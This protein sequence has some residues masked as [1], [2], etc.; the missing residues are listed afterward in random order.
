[1]K[2]TCEFCKW[3]NDE[4]YECENSLIK[5]DAELSENTLVCYGKCKHEKI[6]IKVGKDFGC[7]HWEEK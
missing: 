4:F 6:T 1:M 7:I 5:I 3:W 2:K